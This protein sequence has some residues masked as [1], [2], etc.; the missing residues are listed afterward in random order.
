[1]QLKANTA[2][3]E[4]R[5]QLE[6]YVKGPEKINFSNKIL[7]CYK[8]LPQVKATHLQKQNKICCDLWLQY[9]DSEEVRRI[10]KNLKLF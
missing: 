3:R 1:M 4:E 7:L 8:I 5:K 6:M 2:E 9:K 10:S